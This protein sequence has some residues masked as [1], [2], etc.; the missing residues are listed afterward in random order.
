MEKETNTTWGECSAS[1]VN[2]AKALVAVQSHIE[3]VKKDAANPFFKSK[4][5]DLA[6]VWDAVRE[7]LAKNGLSVLQEPGTDG[8][9]AALTTT[10]LHTSGEY[11]RS[12]MSV[13]VAKQDPQG[14]G[15]AI[16]YMR[17]YA[18]QSVLGVA[19]E[20]DDGNAAS[21]GTAKQMSQAIKKV[22]DEK[23]KEF[24]GKHFSAPEDQLPWDA[25][26]EAAEE[27]LYHIPYAGGEEARKAAKAAGAKWDKD[28]KIWVSPDPVKGLEEFKV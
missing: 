27:H 19:P 28:R 3:P 5:A 15:S 17:R 18:L 7:P 12:R 20:D 10:L 21:V 2:L 4:Y 25:P 14:Y 11:T 24:N 6:T 23:Q 16:T 26:D 22:A 13:P 1:I 9:R 8:D